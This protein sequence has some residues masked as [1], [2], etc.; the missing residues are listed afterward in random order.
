M[1]RTA[2]H[3]ALDMALSDDAPT[4]DRQNALSLILA[5][6]RDHFSPGE[7][8]HA[9]RQV[10]PEPLTDKSIGQ[11]MVEEQMAA[12]LAAYRETGDARDLAEWTSR[13]L[14]STTA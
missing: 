3:D 9:L 1:I 4:G 11:E 5:Q 2:L 10:W 7:F 13:H 8:R 14:K 6:I 12:G